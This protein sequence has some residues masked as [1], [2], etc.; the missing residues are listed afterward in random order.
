MTQRIRT[1]LVVDDHAAARLLHKTLLQSL[2]YDVAVACDGREAIAV[3]NQQPIDAVVSDLQMPVL[4]GF[5]LARAVASRPNWR[6]V[7]MVAVTASHAD[8][9]ENLVRDAGFDVLLSKPVEWLELKSAID[10][11]QWQSPRASTHL[12]RQTHSRGS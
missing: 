7:G 4:D 5:G 6:H 2:G 3:L 9:L 10:S 12:T 1:I 8:N 11:L